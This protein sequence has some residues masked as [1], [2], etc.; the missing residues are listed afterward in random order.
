MK[1]TRYRKNQ[2]TIQRNG[3]DRSH[4]TKEKNNKITVVDTTMRMQT[5]IT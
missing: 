3:Q 2:R 1:N 5:Q 4:K